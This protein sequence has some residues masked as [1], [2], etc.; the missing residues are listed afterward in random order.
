M[1]DPA[2]G[3]ARAG[4]VMLNGLRPMGFRAFAAIWFDPAIAAW[5]GS[6]RFRK[7]M[8]MILLVLVIGIVGGLGTMMAPTA[9]AWAACSVG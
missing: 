9:I 6:G 1:R 5:D 3:G 7:E 4:L 8:I 2:S